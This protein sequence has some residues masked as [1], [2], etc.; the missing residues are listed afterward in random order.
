GIVRLVGTVL[1]M[2]SL[3]EGFMPNPSDKSTVT[4]G[5]KQYSKYKRLWRAV[6]YKAHDEDFTTLLWPEKKSKELFVNLYEEARRDG[7]LDSYSQEYLNV[8]LDISNAFYRRTD[9]L[10]IKAEEKDQPLN[11]YITG[12]LAISESDKAD[13]SV[14]IVAGVTASRHVHIIDVI[15]ER[16]D[17]KEI[18]DTMLALQRTYEPVAFGLEEMQV[19]KSIRPFLYEEM[20]KTNT[21]IAL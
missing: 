13:Y 15:R 18:V 11:Y 12:D 14:F 7:T 3:L 19:S 9:F 17:G 16:L 4:L 10:P 21:Y 2:D 8:P 6:K 1:H 5:L 20:V